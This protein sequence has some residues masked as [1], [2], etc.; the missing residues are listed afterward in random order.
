MNNA[1]TTPDPHIRQLASL[2]VTS[3]PKFGRWAE[4]IRDYETPWGKVGYRQLELLW[5]IR[6]HLAA[7]GDPTPSALAGYYDIQPSVI[8]R[9]LARLEAHGFVTRQSDPGDGRRSYIRIT[10]TG[11]LVSKYVEELY[12]QEVLAAVAGLEPAALA[13]LQR[14]VTM[15]D[16]I[17]DTLLASRL[18]PSVA[19]RESHGRLRQQDH[20]PHLA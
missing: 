10:D 1:A 14:A 15:L 16:R 17:S 3:L 12:I 8:T 20:E 2:M 9:V 5:C 6:H 7:E 13:E 4:A 19:T 11:V 18:Q